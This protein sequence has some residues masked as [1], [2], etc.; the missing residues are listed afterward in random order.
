ME[1]KGKGKAKGEK[2]KGRGK[3][4]SKPEIKPNKAMKPLW[5]RRLVGDLHDTIW[6]SVQEP[7]L[8]VELLEARFSKLPKAAPVQQ[9]QDLIRLSAVHERDV[10]LPPPAEL[11]ER[12]K[13][14][15]DRL[16]LDELER[17]QQLLPSLKDLEAL[18][19]AQEQRPSAALG[20]VE[21]YWLMFTEIPSYRKR[22]EL[23]HFARTYHERCSLQ[24]EHLVDLVDTFSSFRSEALAA[25]LALILA[26]GNRMNHEEATAFD[27]HL[28]QEL[29]E[30]K[31]AQ[32]SL[33]HLIFKDFFDSASRLK[34]ALLLESYWFL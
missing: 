3:C 33:Q 28:L 14:L 11:L 18:K 10:R 5:W 8:P 32:S 27:L 23:W 25:L 26:T 34:E 31:G 16:A 1:G 29:Y 2:G 12:I 22:L 17:L 4:V 9:E 30:V 6:K 15:D 19:L 20:R 21:Q 13:S 24:N 7:S